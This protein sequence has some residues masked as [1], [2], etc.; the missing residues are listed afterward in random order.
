MLHR[1]VIPAIVLAAPAF[2]TDLASIPFKTLAGKET[3]LK[4]YAGKVVLVVNT[5]SKCGLTPQYE[6]L[7]AL[8]GKYQDR[9]FVV[10]GFPSN[11][12]NNQEPG[13]AE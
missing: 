5:A 6:K 11:D 2:A 13:T 10:L 1:I 7:E 12:F 8:Y 9:G 4:D 3:S